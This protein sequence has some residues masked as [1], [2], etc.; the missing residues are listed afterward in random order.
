M[1]TRFILSLLACLL[2]PSTHAADE[3]NLLPPEEAFHFTAV[4]SQPGVLS[5][6]WDIAEGYYLYRSKFKFNSND[7]S[8]LAQAKFPAGE[9]KH[10][11][12]F[13]EIETYRGH[14]DI[15][16]P[17]TRNNLSENTLELE[18]V[19]QGCA[20]IGVCYP[21]QKMTLPI[22]LA[23]A[24]STD[25]SASKSPLGVLKNLS[26]NLGT[27]EPELL[28]PDQAFIFKAEL[29]GSNSLVTEWIVAEGYYLY[30]DK[31]K[32]ALQDSTG[33]SLGDPTFPDS[34]RLDDP[35]YGDVEIFRGP[36][37]VT[38]PILGLS[39]QP[40]TLDLNA[41]YQGCADIGVCY[42]PIKK[43]VSFT[44]EQLK[45]LSS[46]PT[47]TTEPSSTPPTPSNTDVGKVSE[48]DAIAAK[49]SSGNTPLT[50][51]S[52][53]G[54]GLLLAFTPCVFPMIPILSGI[55]VG[56]GDKISAS[57]GFMLALAYVL[58]MAFAYTVVGVL[59]GLFGSNLQVWFQNPW[60]LGGFAIVFVLLALSM[61]GFYEL[62]MPS[63]IQGK[64][65]AISNKQSSGKMMS[66]AI[67]G[68]LS[69]LIVGPCVTAPL[70]GALIYIGQTGDAVLGGMA[71]FA[72]SMGMGAPLLVLGA[73]AGKLLPKAGPW[74]D[75]IKSVFGV[76]LLGVAIWLLERILPPSATLLLWGILLVVSGIYMGALH[77]TIQESRWYLLWK[78]LGVVI[79]LYGS[80]MIIG[81]AA[82]TRNTLQPL[83]GLFATHSTSGTHKSELSFQ[84]IKGPKGLKDA[85][86]QIST[87]GKTAMLDF[88]ADWCISCKEMEANT[89]SASSVQ[90]A[91]SNTVLLKSDVTANDAQDKALLKQFGLIG[92][93]AILFFDKKGKEKTGYR[94]VGFVPAEKFRQHAQEALD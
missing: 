3:D 16:I 93:P 91:L 46:N 79:L 38:F 74:M 39:N 65:S 86:A 69:A 5:A 28:E 66:A 72:L 41:G 58:A 31:I 30:K 17:Y 47:T 63:S 75:T 49:L 85:L 8:Q 48:Q 50:L 76:L 18:A 81:A 67:M 15:S 35:Q 20:D 6:R 68:L 12:F 43:Q 11:E 61:F 84:Y 7:D 51:L 87:D 77:H 59:A 2:L 24:D 78:G 90:K 26:N 27:D 34:T 73:S 21:P 83:K 13:G 70:I 89:F 25:S 52:F 80:L 60:I 37:T 88:Y 53:F 56:E 44:A 22:Q 92:P 57:R 23:Q 42:P 4:E 32:M 45:Q 94:V 9:K 14:I 29:N 54:F 19:Y 64:L 36:L 1:L 10:D 82:D 62:Q 55:I 40:S 71:L 33:L